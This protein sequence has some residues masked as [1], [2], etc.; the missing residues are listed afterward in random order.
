MCAS[1][2]MD[3]VYFVQSN[4]QIVLAIRPIHMEVPFSVLLLLSVSLFPIPCVSSQLYLQAAKGFHILSILQASC[5]LME[6]SMPGRRK[7]PF[8]EDAAA[9]LLMLS[10][11]RW[12]S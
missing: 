5:F 1:C 3:Q 10:A 11:G 4:T 7:W 12:D 6:V 2:S 9:A 8:L